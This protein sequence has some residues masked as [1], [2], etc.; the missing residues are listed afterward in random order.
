MKELVTVDNFT[1]WDDLWDG[2]ITA[3]S[4]GIPLH[5]NQGILFCNGDLEA[6][7]YATGDT[8]KQHKKIYNPSGIKPKN[9]E[10]L[11]ALQLLQ[12]RS[13][14]LTILSGE[15]G[16]GKTLLA[17]AHALAKFSTDKR[18]KRIMIAKSMTPVGREIGFLKGEMSDK[19]KPWLGPF[20]DNFKV[21]GQ[22]TAQIDQMIEGELIEIT[23]ITFIQGRSIKD[24]V[25]IID[26]V[27][28]LGMDVIKQI[29]TRAAEGSE[30][31]LLGDPT[32][33]FEGKLRINSLATLIEAGKNSPLVG[34]VH[35]NTCFRSAIAG[36]AVEHL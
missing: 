24:T 34:H 27:Q 11:I 30:I 10:Q 17:V 20:Y 31:I 14:P 21:C 1:Q 4:L 13:I 32:Q 5:E 2:K 8:I 33:K 23:P 19:V 26:E 3:A 35:L 29:I 16:S 22:T 6:W 7:G 25:L 9:G 28:N 15:A 12:N 36:W 18:V